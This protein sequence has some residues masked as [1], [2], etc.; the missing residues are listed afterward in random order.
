MYKKLKL[1]E[2]RTHEKIT[3]R[4]QNLNNKSCR[5]TKERTKILIKNEHNQTDLN[6]RVQACQTMH[7][8]NCLRTPCL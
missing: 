5:E 7:T 1:G 3:K 2:G 6:Y 4:S 8:K